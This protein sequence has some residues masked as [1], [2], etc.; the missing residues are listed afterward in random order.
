VRPGEK[1]RLAVDNTSFHFFDPETGQAVGTR[2]TAAEPAG[3]P[4]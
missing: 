1:V 2:A 4:A 3:A